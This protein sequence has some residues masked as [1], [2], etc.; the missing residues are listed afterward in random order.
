MPRRIALPTL[1]KLFRYSPGRRQPVLGRARRSVN[2]F[3]ERLEDRCLLSYV[4]TNTS[5]SGTGSLGFEIAAAIAGPQPAEITFSGLPDNSTIQLTASDVSSATAEYGP[6][7]F[8]IDGTSGTNITI[9]GSGAPG[10]VID[11]GNAVRLFTVASGDSL[12]MENLLL[13]HGYAFGGAG[14]ASGGGGGAGLGGAVFDDDGSFTAQGCTFVDNQAVGGQ[15]GLASFGGGGG[16][17]LG[18][19]AGLNGGG[20]N[21]GPAGGGGF[22]GEGHAGGGF[23]G[24]GGGGSY[25]GSYSGDR[26]GFGG[27]FGGGGGG[28]AAGFGGFGGDGGSG[29]FGGF[30]GGGLGGDGAP[31]GEVGGSG[32]FGGGRGGNGDALELDLVSGGGGGGMG[33]GIFSNQARS[34]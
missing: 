30:G 4:V 16:G 22:E 26:G 9:D 27:G 23:G 5:Y 2:R 33:G 34:P 6:T 11:G 8:F 1:K 17:G 10:L 21:G 3:L 18:A 19:S 15:G 29:G 31:N 7:A 12:S 24:G 25:N 14:A 13:Q 32:G 28:G 20:V